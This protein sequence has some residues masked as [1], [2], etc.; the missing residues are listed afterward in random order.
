[1]FYI[2][3]LYMLYVK[4]GFIYRDVIVRLWLGSSLIEYLMPNQ[5][6]SQLLLTT[7]T[8]IKQMHMHTCTVSVFFSS[9]YNTSLC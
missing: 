7:M 4:L 9:H 5:Q 2:V 6:V 1:M 8:N 3:I